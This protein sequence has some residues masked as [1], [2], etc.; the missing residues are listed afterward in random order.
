M[1]TATADVGKARLRIDGLKADRA[2]LG[3]SAKDYGG[4]FGVSALT[5]Y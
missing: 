5:I 2:K 4:L 3:L 1:K